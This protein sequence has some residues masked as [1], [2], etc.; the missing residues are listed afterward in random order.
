MKHQEAGRGLFLAGALAGTAMLLLVG[1][2]DLHKHEAVESV[3]SG[4]SAEIRQQA[5]MGL[6]AERVAQGEVGDPQARRWVF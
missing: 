3:P 1:N 4:L 6:Q 5:I 2:A